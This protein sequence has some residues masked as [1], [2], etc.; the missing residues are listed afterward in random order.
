MKMQRGKEFVRQILGSGRYSFTLAEASAATGVKGQALNMLLQRLKKDRWVVPFSKGFYLALDAQHQSAGMLDPELFIDDWAGYLGAQYYVCGLTAA[1]AY[2]AAHQR[3]AVFQVMM[4]RR[5]RSVKRGG[6]SVQVCFRKTIP[7]KAIDKRKSPAGYY[8]IS[9]P[10]LTA[11]DVVAS[12]RC[13][14]SL[15][16]AATVF[17]ELGEVVDT[18]RLAALPG[19]PC[20]TAALQRMGWMLERCGWKDKTAE[21]HATMQD[22]RRPWRPLDPRLSP[23]GRRN[24]RWKVVENTEVEP[25]LVR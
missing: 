14:P 24:E 4:N 12:T 15:D 23:E 16:L 13:C 25:D 22:V 5:V 11:Y 19:L 9:S 8:R 21:L 17:A 7:T 10:E 18:G 1:A 6:I 2:G 20:K 3:P